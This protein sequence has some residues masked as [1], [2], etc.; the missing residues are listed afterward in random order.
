MIRTLHTSF[1]SWVG[2]LLISLL[3]GCA[4]EPP[5]ADTP[6]DADVPIEEPVTGLPEAPPLGAPRPKVTPGVLIEEDED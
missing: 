6:E 1:V 2:T 4:S 3:T 5:Q